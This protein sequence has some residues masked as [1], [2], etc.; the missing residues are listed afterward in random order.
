[1]E[2]RPHRSLAKKGRLGMGCPEREIGGRLEET[3]RQEGKG[4][5]GQKGEQDTGEQGHALRRSRPSKGR[6]PGLQANR[7]A[8]EQARERKDGE[9]EVRKSH[10]GLVEPEARSSAGVRGVRGARV[11]RV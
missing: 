6:R 11:S 9:Q 2:R 7:E 4:Q 10:Q 5:P 8:A 3:G 1:M